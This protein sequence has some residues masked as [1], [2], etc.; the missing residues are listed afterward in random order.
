MKSHESQEDYLEAILKL[1]ETNNEVRAVD[2][3]NELQYSKA[4]VSVAMKKLRA[5][6]YATVADNGAI[7]LTKSGE[8]IAQAVYYRHKTLSSFF[9]GM[10]VSHEIASED[11]CRIE[12][13]LSEETFSALINHIEHHKELEKC[14]S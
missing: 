2:I 13:Y 9:E 14:C 10:G 5:A 4:S 3:A 1:S 11:A 6:G 7:S 8:K 12:H